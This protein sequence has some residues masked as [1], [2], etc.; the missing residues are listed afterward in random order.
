[1]EKDS[2]SII[3]TSFIILIRLESKQNKYLKKVKS[4]HNVSFDKIRF[5]RKSGFLNKK[6]ILSGQ[7]VI[8]PEGWNL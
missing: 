4:F 1:M 6:V 3:L 5:E 2:V 8:I 7:K